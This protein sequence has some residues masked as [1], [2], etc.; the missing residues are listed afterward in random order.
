LRPKRISL[1]TTALFTSEQNGRAERDNRLLIE[2]ARAI[3]YAKNLPVKLWAEAINTACYI[4]N[5]TPTV[6]NQGVTPYEIWINRKPRLN[7]I[8]VFGSEAYA[9]IPKQLRKKW[10]KKS[11]KLLIGYQADSC[12]Y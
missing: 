12:N 8:R 6:N 1:E 10:D 3:L 9:H 4:L 7:Y 5:R 2:S 11:Q